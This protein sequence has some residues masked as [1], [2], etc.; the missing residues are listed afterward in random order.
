MLQSTEKKRG[1]PLYSSMRERETLITPLLP[2]YLHFL[3]ETG[4]VLPLGQI[5]L[6]FSVNAVSQPKTLVW[7]PSSPKDVKNWLYKHAVWNTWKP[8]SAQRQRRMQT[9]LLTV[10]VLELML[11]GVGTTVDPDTKPI[12]VQHLAK[13]TW[14]LFFKSR[15]AAVFLFNGLLCI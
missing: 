12:S 5:L 4:G 6:H 2:H 11:V 3:K 10:C 1:T 8:D 13:K 9:F 7:K 15:H 14:K